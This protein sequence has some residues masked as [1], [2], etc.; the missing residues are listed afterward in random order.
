MKGVG[1]K[2][3]PGEPGKKLKKVELG[4]KSL[5][6]LVAEDAGRVRGGGNKV[7]TPHT[8]TLYICN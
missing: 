1:T 2:R 4:K 5:K 7:N 8:T 6:D 3:Q